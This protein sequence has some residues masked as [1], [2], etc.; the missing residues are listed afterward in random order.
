VLYFREENGA[1]ERG[2][3]RSFRGVGQAVAA[4]MHRKGNAKDCDIAD[5]GGRQRLT[6]TSGLGRQENLFCHTSVS[7]V[8]AYCLSVASLGFYSCLIKGKKDF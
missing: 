8:K 2:A 7:A 6:G 1:R 4:L 3:H 5:V